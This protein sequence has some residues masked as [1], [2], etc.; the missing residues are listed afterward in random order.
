MPRR[1]L[2]AYTDLSAK[3]SLYVRI[4]GEV[5]RVSSYV[6]WSAINEIPKA[7]L[8]LAVGRRVSLARTLYAKIHQTGD[9]LQ[10]MVRAKVFFTPSGDYSP[11]GRQWPTGTKVIFEGWLVGVTRNKNLGKISVV[12]TLAHWIS[13]LTFSSMLAV[14]GHTANPSAINTR[15][16]YK[17]LNTTGVATGTTLSSLDRSINSTNITLDLWGTYKNMFCNLATRSTASIRVGDCV[18]Q[19]GTPY[20]SNGAAFEALARMEGP[21]QDGCQM[22]YKFAR[23]LALNVANSVAVSTGLSRALGKEAISNLSGLT[24]WDNL[25]QTLVPA[26]LVAVVPMVSRVLVVPYVPTL[27]SFWKEI[28]PIETT[29]EDATTSLDYPIRSIGI[30]EP[31]ASV[32]NAAEGNRRNNIV[33]GGCFAANVGP[34]DYG[35]NLFVGAPLWLRTLASTF[36]SFRSSSGSGNNGATPSA[37]TPAV[38]PPPAESS[39]LSPADIGELYDRYARALYTMHNV[40]GRGV[41]LACKLRFDIAPGSNVKI[42]F[43][44]ET[45]IGSEDKLALTQYGNVNRVTTVINAEA[46]RAAT[47]LSITHVRNQRENEQDGT[48]VEAHPLFT[49]DSIHGLGKHGAPLLP[50]YDI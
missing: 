9:R 19:T 34:E 26:F 2:W 31:F 47:T 10:T 22:D 21:S 3:N 32:T 27:R 28:K 25:I 7:Q 13:S 5:Y 15:A 23:P 43:E 29:V 44:P 4:D 8:T 35:V 11:D 39:A 36:G 20:T 12:V 24:F 16:V 42:S 17:S 14:D 46:G 48:S 1:K 18:T 37:L 50:D 33:V 38:T 41:I 49:P 40:R 6:S 45:F 30:V